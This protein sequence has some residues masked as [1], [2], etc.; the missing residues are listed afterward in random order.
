MS[1]AIN[2]RSFEVNVTVV[3]V[4]SEMSLNGT[5]TFRLKCVRIGCRSL[6]VFDQRHCNDVSVAVAIRT[7]NSSRFHYTMEFRVPR[8]GA[9]LLR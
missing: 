1:D 9:G 2:G 4:V 8:S 5:E 6:S 7:F 3:I